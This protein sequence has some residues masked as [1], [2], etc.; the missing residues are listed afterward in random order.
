[1]ENFTEAETQRK[2]RKKFQRLRQKADDSF[3]WKFSKNALVEEKRKRM[4][5]NTE[6]SSGNV[7]TSSDI[8]EAGG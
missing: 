7:S 5:G 3:I 4:L 8:E 2:Y 1:M 6:W